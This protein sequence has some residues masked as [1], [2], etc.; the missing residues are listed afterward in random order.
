M[1]RPDETILRVCARSLILSLV[2]LT[3]LEL[4]GLRV[5]M[6]FGVCDVA[7]VGVDPWCDGLSRRL[8]SIRTIG[9]KM[10]ERGDLM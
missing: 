1:L 3:F 9:V 10:E 4:T 2:T 5:L 8:W 6:G 7:D